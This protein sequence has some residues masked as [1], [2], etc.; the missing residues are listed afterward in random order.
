MEDLRYPIGEFQPPSQVTPAERQGCVEQIEAHPARLEAAVRGLDAR[1]LDTRYREGGWTVRQ[2]VHHLADS[3]VNGFVRFRLA[4]TEDEPTI[5]PYAP[6]LWGEL[7]DSRS[8][9]VELSL[10]LLKA[11]H[12][13]WVRLLQSLSED[14]WARR[15]RHPELGLEPLSVTA[16]KYAWH[17]RHHV[18]HI[19]RLKDREGW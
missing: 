15:A 11:L 17:G 8:A 9:P 16:A 12:E 1:Q 3:H 10:A 6:D 2:V 19:T 18:A 13:R 7:S 4:L 5:K 14:Q